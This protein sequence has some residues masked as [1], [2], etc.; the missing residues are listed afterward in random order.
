M[1][2]TDGSCVARLDSLHSIN[3]ISAG[4]RRQMSWKE[5]YFRPIIST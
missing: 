3:I 2:F 5:S 4:G 1:K